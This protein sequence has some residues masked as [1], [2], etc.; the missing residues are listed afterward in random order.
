VTGATGLIGPTG[1]GQTGSTGL[2]GPAGTPG[3]VG[4]KG[5]AG[6]GVKAMAYVSPDG[7]SDS[8]SLSTVS[9]VASTDGRGY[10]G[11]HYCV[12][13]AA[14]VLPVAGIVTVTPEASWNQAFANASAPGSCQIDPAHPNSRAMWVE[15][16]QL[17]S[18][19][20]FVGAKHGF[21]IVVA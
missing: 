4:P 2:A 11:F 3:G 17:N 1:T 5:D 21:S 12:E 14:S 10:N 6:Q 20:Q 16:F 18:T 9:V 8:S 7:I 15:I 13:L 19:S